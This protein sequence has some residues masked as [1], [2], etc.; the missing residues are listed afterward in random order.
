MSVYPNRRELLIDTEEGR[1]YAA[2]VYMCPECSKFYTPR[3]GKLLSEGDEYILDF[4]DDIKASEDYKK[5]YWKKRWKRTATVISICM[6]QNILIKYIM[7]IEVLHK[8][9]VI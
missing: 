7:E 3:P 9:A 2:R 6:K 8:S 5:T 1:V 4:D